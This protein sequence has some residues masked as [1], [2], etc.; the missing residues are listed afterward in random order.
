MF[1]QTKDKEQTLFATINMKNQEIIIYNEQ[2]M[3][4]WIKKE[5]INPKAKPDEALYT[6]EEVRSIEEYFSPLIEQNFSLIV[7]EPNEDM[8]LQIKSY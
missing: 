2:M 3:Q 5:T 4:D 7:S 8:E 1:D 6:G